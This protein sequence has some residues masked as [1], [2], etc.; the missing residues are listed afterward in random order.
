LIGCKH[1]FFY[2]ASERNA[3]L[4]LR[5]SLAVVELVGHDCG[6]GCNLN[7][8]CRRIVKRKAEGRLVLLYRRRKKEDN[9]Y[10]YT[11]GI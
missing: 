2:Y 3:Y 9:T 6:D 10:I 11:S 4:D 8:R 7:G 1:T 5:G